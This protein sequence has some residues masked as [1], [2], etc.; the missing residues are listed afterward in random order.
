MLFLP[1]RFSVPDASDQLSR[2]LLAY[3]N[4][5]RCL[6]LPPPRLE[7]NLPRTPAPAIP[8]LPAAPNNSAITIP[9]TTN[10]APHHA[11]DAQPFLQH[12]VRSNHRK[13][14][15]QRKQIAACPGDVYCCAHNCTVNA[16]AVA[17]TAQIPMPSSKPQPPR[18]P[19]RLPVN[20]RS[21]LPSAATPSPRIPPLE[22][23]S[24]RD[25]EC[26]CVNS[27]TRMMCTA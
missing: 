16:T 22:S 7:I 25:T 4:G 3:G 27:P 10:P 13:H 5:L 1:R 11:R 2:V 24:A 6:S 18:K 26:S 12:E 21:L 15:L 14:R 20:R 17:N 8:A 19:H 9:A 23:S